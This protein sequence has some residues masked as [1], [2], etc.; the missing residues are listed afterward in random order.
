MD[1]IG[2]IAVAK[3]SKSIVGFVCGKGLR[4]A[5]SMIVGDVHLSA[6]K[7]AL[8]TSG[9]SAS[10]RDRIN[11][12]ITHLEAAHCAFEAVHSRVSGLKDKSTNWQQIRNA[13]AKDAW[14]CCLMALCYAYLEDSEAVK[15]SLHLAEAAFSNGKLEK[16]ISNAGALIGIPLA[17][18]GLLNPRNWDF[19]GESLIN[20]PQF[21]EFRAAL[22]GRASH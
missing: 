9:I 8:Q 2:L 21:R 3:H 1:A 18:I 13:V 15:G 22:E 7:L 19:H 12:A 16:E 6:A 4:E 20:E 10:P 17:L 11:S 14:I 5:V